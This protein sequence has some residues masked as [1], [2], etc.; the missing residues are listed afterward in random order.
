MCL[1]AQKQIE[2]FR[3]EAFTDLYLLEIKMKHLYVTV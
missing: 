1:H 3:N 2:C